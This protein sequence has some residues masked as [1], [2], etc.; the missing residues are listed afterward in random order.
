MP[1][2]AKAL[3]LRWLAQRSLTV[4]EVQQRL[5]KR[6]FS[7]DEIAETVKELANAALLDDERVA[8][9][10]SQQ[11]L[12]RHEGPRRLWGRL[13]TRGIDGDL[14]HQAVKQLEDKVNWLEIAE[15]LLARYDIDNPK[16]R[17]RLIRRMAREGF[18]A[19]VIYRLAGGE[20]SEERGGLDD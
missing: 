18:P 6:G 17:A 1:N 11:S 4:H 5:S 16:D 14:A 7:P 8:E 15:P 9:A 13:M 2:E 19:A 12:V 20:R 10:V 3:T